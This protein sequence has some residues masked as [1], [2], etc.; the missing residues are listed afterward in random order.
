VRTDVDYTIRWGHLGG[1]LAG[2]RNGGTLL[3]AATIHDDAAVD[4]LFGE[5]DRDW[6]FALLSGPYQ[7]RIM[8][9]G[10]GEAVTQL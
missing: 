1:Q 2:G 5:G 10:H 6:F 8:D 4:T 9:R 7:D 3:T